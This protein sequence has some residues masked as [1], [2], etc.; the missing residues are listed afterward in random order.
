MKSIE[1]SQQL[2]CRIE[3]EDLVIRIGIPLLMFALENGPSWSEGFKIT[4]PIA[5][6]EA[7]ASHLE[8]DEDGEDGT[9]AV[10]RILDEAAEHAIESDCEGVEEV[11]TDDEDA[12]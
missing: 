9:T 12:E 2:I 8:N 7:I 5:F 3:G 4:D 1:E 10:H 11:E 6:A